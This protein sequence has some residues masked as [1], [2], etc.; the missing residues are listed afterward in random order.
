MIWRETVREWEE[1][2]LLVAEFVDPLEPAQCVMGRA[3]TV[4]VAAVT[5]E[6][7]Y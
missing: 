4:V 2:H 3:A 7:S 1:E 6:T 5:G